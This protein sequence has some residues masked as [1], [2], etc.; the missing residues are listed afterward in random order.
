MFEF[1][2]SGALLSTASF[3]FSLRVGGAKN[4]VRK[5]ITQ[6]DLQRRSQTG[7]GSLQAKWN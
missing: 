6:V 5:T 7:S 1:L 3:Y 4:V 2:L